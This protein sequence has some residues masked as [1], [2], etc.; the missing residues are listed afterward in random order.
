MKNKILCGINS[1]LCV[2]VVISLFLP[3]DCTYIY[4]INDIKLN[5]NG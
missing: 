5:Y 1:T 2:T 3:I 4:G